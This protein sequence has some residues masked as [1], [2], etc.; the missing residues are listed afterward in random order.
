MSYDLCL[1]RFYRKPRASKFDLFALI[2]R[3]A[4]MNYPPFGHIGFKTLVV[5]WGINSA[6]HMKTKEMQRY[7][8]IRL[9]AEIAR[10]MK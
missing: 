10:K 8:K 6:V 9:L 1:D 4:K 7:E 5:L 3:I 2:S